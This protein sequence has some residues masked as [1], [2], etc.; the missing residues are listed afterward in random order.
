MEVRMSYLDP[1]V[2]FF[3]IGESARTFVGEK[4]AVVVCREPGAV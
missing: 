2:D 4:E 1:V 3:V